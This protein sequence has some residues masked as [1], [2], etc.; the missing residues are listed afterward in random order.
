MSPELFLP[1]I[2]FLDVV[3]PEIEPSL[4]N[5][6]ISNICELINDDSEIS[7]A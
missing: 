4:L 3:L 5:D 7:R 2:R 6:L 1:L